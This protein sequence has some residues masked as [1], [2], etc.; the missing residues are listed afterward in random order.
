MP[1][2]KRAVKI[3]RAHHA[4]KANNDIV[5]QLERFQLGFNDAE[6][7]LVSGAHYKLEKTTVYASNRIGCSI[8]PPTHD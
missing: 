3:V 2:K 5:A 8:Y 6:D 7:F 1:S 4:M